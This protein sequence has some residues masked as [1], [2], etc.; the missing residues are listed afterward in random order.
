MATKTLCPLTRQEF[1]TN[2]TPQG[3]R[4]GSEGQW[5]YANPKAFS[6]GS[7]GFCLTGK[8]LIDVG[9]CQVAT[10]VSLNLT[11]VGS[12]DLP[13]EKDLCCNHTTGQYRDDISA[14]DDLPSK[15]YFAKHAKPV[16]VTIGTQLLA[17]YPK[18][19]ASG[20]VGWYAGGKMHLSV[21]GTLVAFQLGVNL[22]AIG[23]DSLSEAGIPVKDTTPEMAAA[24]KAKMAEYEAA[25]SDIAKYLERGT[26]TQAEADELRKLAIADC[27][28]LVA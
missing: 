8:A 27:A 12:K 25:Q 17:A 15:D 23:S 24:I 3:I 6:T 11:A 9:D 28:A 21:N 7:V 10:Q 5:T 19:F 26:I 4:I 14:A 18:R 2:A 22:V 1:L 16:H 13:A 20:K